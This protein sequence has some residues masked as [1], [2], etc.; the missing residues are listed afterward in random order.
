MAQRAG[1]AGTLQERFEKKYE[2]IPEAGCWIWTGSV[3]KNGYGHFQVGKSRKTHKLAPA[4]RVS[5]ELNIGS[6]PEG[7]CVLHKCDV[8]ACVN[9]YH[10]FLGTYKDNAMD[11]A[12]KGRQWKQVNKRRGHEF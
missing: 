12:A 7:M 2:P 3:M 11:M 10:L 4:H 8:P 9:P 6:I 5:Y 1:Y